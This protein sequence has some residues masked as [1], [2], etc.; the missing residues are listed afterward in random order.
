MLQLKRFIRRSIAAVVVFACLLSV[1]GG[2]VSAAER[3]SLEFQPSN[4]G[5]MDKPVESIPTTVEV[6]VKLQPNVNTRQIIIGNYQDGKKNSWSLELTADNRLRYWEEYYDA[7]GVKKG[8]SNLY[9]TGVDVATNEW[10]LLSVVRDVANQKITFYK[11]GTQVFEKTG[12]TAIAPA[13][14]P[15]P[16][17]M[18]VGTDYRKSMWLNGKVSEIRLWNVMRTPQEIT[19]YV[20]TELTGSEPGLAHAWRLSDAEGVSP[21]TTFNDMIRTNPIK[22]T[23]EGFQA[24]SVGSGVDY[25]HSFNAAGISFASSDEQYGMKNRLSDIPRSFE[26]LIKLPKDLQGNRGGNIAS[27]YME[28]GYYDY[29]LPYVNFEVTAK[30]EPRLYWKKQGKV[31]DTVITGVDLRQDKWVH[32]AMTFDET[33]DQIKCYINGKLVATQLNVAF[34][35]DIPAQPLKIGGDYRNGNSQYFKGEIAN[36]RIWS[37]VRTAQEID[38]SMETEPAN[39]TGLLGSWKFETAVNG[40]YADNSPNG[41]DVS[42]FVDWIAPTFAKGD[43]SMV[44]LPDTQFLTESF[45]DKYYS[46]MSWIKNNK[47]TYNIQAVMSLGDIVNVPSSETQ[48]QVAQNGYNILNDVVPYMVLP[49]NHD[50]SMSLNRA[51]VNFN[52]YF[53]YSKFSQ[54]SYFGGAYKEGYMDNAYYY[55]TVGDKQYMIFSLAFAPNQDILNWVNEQIDAHPEKSVILTTHAYLY[56][57]GEQLSNTYIDYP[58]K[59]ISDAKNGDD[60]W[61]EVASQHKNVILVLSGHIGFPDLVNRVDTGIHGNRVNQ[62]LADAQGMD[63]Q[64]G[65]YAML[66]MLTFHHDSSKVDVNWYSADKNELYRERNQFTLDLDNVEVTGVQVDKPQVSL[67]VGQTAELVATVLPENVTNKKVTWSSSDDTVA[68]VEISGGK[69]V[70][71]ALKEGVA[72]ITVTTVGGNFTAVSK[73]TVQGDVTPNVALTTVSAADTVQTGTEFSVQLGLSSVTQSVY[74]QDIKMDY[75]SNVF[76]FVSAGTVKEGILLVETVKDTLGKLRFIL[77]NVGKAVTGDAAILE[78]KFKA[79][80]MSQQATGRIAVTDATLA[81][82]QGAET[83]TQTSTVGVRIATL[84]PGIPGDVNHDNKTSIGDLGIVAANYGK[85]SSSQDWEQIKQADA[86][87]DGKIDIED[88]AFVASKIME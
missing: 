2:N 43:Y 20:T 22:I 45:P 47:S 76:D 55:V 16:L 56:W 53:P 72:D 40:V 88:L 84:P 49:G 48:W 69:T 78:L 58:S 51:A 17:P 8:I 18:Y 74:A 11:N 27:N 39:P 86:T 25:S 7:Q 13:N 63:L 66:M 6:W 19:Q 28:A 35:P 80:A 30:G 36:L 32:V 34:Q 85:T 79:K 52:K 62:L 75:D 70:V 9:V 57:N 54:M 68:N 61:K 77:A 50:M 82:G 31:Q 65:G 26:A 5:I 73:I 33:T 21:T 59:Y 42:A 71:T 87:G 24:S 64:N 41:N 4:Y 37:T 29:D 83:K 60:V 67:K 15:S 12:Y 14:T 1:I 38:A 81:D 44:V 46:M 23:T 10:M 3:A